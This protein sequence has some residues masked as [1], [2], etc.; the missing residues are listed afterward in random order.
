MTRLSIYRPN[1]IR[2]ASNNSSTGLLNRFFDETGDCR[3]YFAMPPANIAENDDEYR[4]ELAVP[5]Y[6]KSDFNI[7]VNKN[8]L[9][10][11]LESEEQK[12]SP[13]DYILKEFG[14]NGFK[15]SFRLSEK[16]DKEN[17]RARYDDGMLVIAVPKKDEMKNRPIEIQ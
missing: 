10:V 8:L 3:Q 4:I 11:G 13:Q 2:E 16:V 17:I 15:R 7:E 12:N 14:F 1:R 9:E 5:G 6:A